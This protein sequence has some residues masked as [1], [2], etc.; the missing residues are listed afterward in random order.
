MP[1]RSFVQQAK[2]LEP[3]LVK[4]RRTLHQMPELGFELPKTSA[5]VWERLTEIGL[6]PKRCGKTGITCTIGS[7]GKTIL[8]R[9]D[10][11]ALPIKEESGLPFASACENSHACGHDF[12][13]SM[14]LAAATILKRNEASLKGTVKVMFQPAEEILGGASAM[15]ADGLLENP[16]V[17]A[18]IGMHI[19]V[20]QP[21]SRVGTVMSVQGASNYSA[22]DIR[23]HI[24]GCAV[25]GG[26][27]EKGVD[28]V[29][30]A[31]HI[32]IAL[33]E[34]NAREISA[35]DE[36]VVLVGTVNGGSSSNTVAGEATLGVSTR[37]TS[38]ILRQYLKDRIVEISTGVAQTFRGSATVEFKFGIPSVLNDADVSTKV[39]K[40][41]E[42]ILPEGNVFYV[43][44]NISS[45][46][47][48]VITEHVPSV[49]LML[50]CGTPDE[51]YGN[52]CHTSNTMLDERALPTGAALYAYCAARWLEDMQ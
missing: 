28:A 9:C 41:A 48:A 10:M 33:Q 32:I 50:G 40:Y 4:D 20:A 17:D 49:F 42:E 47:F 11:D 37:T 30:I 26:T 31:A 24:K 18:A 45:E 1:Y 6:E 34:L 36:A 16:K 21:Y 8:L 52:L 13:M 25:H 7:G 43:P 39:M 5:Y 22:D 46:D 38:P 51:G 27:P 3:Q 19:I 29:N 44:R 23:I 12:H 2:D 14:M 15:I 35:A